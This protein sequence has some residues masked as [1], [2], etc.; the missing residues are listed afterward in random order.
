LEPSVN[1]RE[2]LQSK[3]VTRCPL[4]GE[5]AWKFGEM[6]GVVMLGS[7]KTDEAGRDPMDTSAGERL[8][9]LGDVARIREELK[10]FRDYLRNLVR[11]ET[12]RELK[13]GHC[14]NVLFLDNK[15]IRESAVS[16]T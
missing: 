7:A 11:T 13:C 16:E 2:W 6:R 14:G 3:G 9:R 4:C 15:T 8:R 12:L 1:I 10:I 5:D